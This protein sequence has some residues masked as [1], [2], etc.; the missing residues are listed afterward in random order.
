MQCQCVIAESRRDS[1]PDRHIYNQEVAVNP[2]V[3]VNTLSLEIASFESQVAAIA[4]LEVAALSPDVAAISTYGVREAQRLITRAGLCI[5]VLTHRAFGFLTAAMARAERDRLRKT[6]DIAHA[7]GAGAICMTSGGRGNVTWPEAAA[8]FAAEIAPCVEYAKTAGIGLGLEPTS[9]LYADVSIVHRLTDTVV[10]AREAGIKVGIDLFAC[11]PDAD[12]EAAIANAGPI[13]AFVQVSD[14]V[15]GDRG[16]PCRAVPGDGAIPLDR[17]LRL[18]MATGFAGPYDL[19]IIG[20]RLAHEGYRRGLQ[21]A[22]TYLTQ[23][24][25]HSV[26]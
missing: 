24:V 3:S 15:L 26:P 25:G 20:P 14:Y 17:L 22:V 23:I 12:V 19:E 5:A 10:L 7:L 18:V 1:V 16:L 21:R 9:H 11:W 2:I 8:R 4:E 6:I 13:C